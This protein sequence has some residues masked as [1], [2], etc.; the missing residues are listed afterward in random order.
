KSGNSF[1]ENRRRRAGWTKELE[2]EIKDAREEPV[3]LLWFVGDYAS[4]DPRSQ[5]VTRAFAR[6]LHDAGV[7]FGILY[8]SEQTAG[9]DIR[10]IGE[11]GLF[12]SL[13]QSNVEL[14]QEA[15]FNRIVTTDPHTL[16]ALRNEYPD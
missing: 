6:I 7:D 4:L 5:R 3:D 13:A 11:E 15:T 14:L 16:N 1:G 8:D 2:F 12:E 10:R 9:N